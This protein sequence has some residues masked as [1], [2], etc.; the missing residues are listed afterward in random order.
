MLENKE[1]KECGALAIE[2]HPVLYTW[3]RVIG[4]MFQRILKEE[5]RP[6]SAESLSVSLALC[7]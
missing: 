6:G 1:V 5:G 7:S 4:E 2:S 3:G